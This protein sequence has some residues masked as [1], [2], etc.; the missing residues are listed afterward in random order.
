MAN[1]EGSPICAFGD[2]LLLGRRVRGRDQHHVAIPLSGCPPGSRAVGFWHT[3]PEG[4]PN[5][6]RKDVSEALRL[7]LD[8][9]CVTVPE[10]GITRCLALTRGR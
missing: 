3:H 9:V 2:E 4:S 7:G 1:E 6:S 8:V 5:P 10:T